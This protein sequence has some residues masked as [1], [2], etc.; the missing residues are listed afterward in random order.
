MASS[1]NAAPSLTPFQSRVYEVVGTIPKGSVRTY[2]SIA[3]ELQTSP[4]AVGTA[5]GR[6]PYGPS[7]EVP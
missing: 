7:D 4:R 3:Q 2:G 1:N 6:N 5:M